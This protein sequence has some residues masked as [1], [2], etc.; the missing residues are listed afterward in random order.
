M[1]TQDKTRRLGFAVQK[2]ARARVLVV[3]AKIAIAE[4]ELRPPHAE[5]LGHELNKLQGTIDRLTTAESTLFNMVDMIEKQYPYSDNGPVVSVCT[6]CGQ[7]EREGER[8]A[9][10][11]DDL[12]YH[13]ACWNEVNDS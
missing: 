8:T 6:H 10:L 7:A 5:R 12:P 11:V 3:D 4:I 9:I 13:H 1:K 2:L